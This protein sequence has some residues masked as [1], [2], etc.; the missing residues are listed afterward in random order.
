MPTPEEYSAY[1]GAH[2]SRLWASLAD[3]WRCPGCGRSRF[4]LLRWTK[5]Y[6]KK[7]HETGKYTDSY[8]GWMARLHRHHDHSVGFV[9]PDSRGRCPVTV[10]C[11]QCNSADGAA[12]RALK[13]QNDF[14]LSPEEI[15]RFVVPT[16]H[17]RHRLDLDEAS[18]IYRALCVPAYVPLCVLHFTAGFSP[19]GAYHRALQLE[20]LAESTGGP[21]FEIFSVAVRGRGVGHEH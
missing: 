12:K 4:E 19:V 8:W 3:D 10:M 11:D 5:R 2:C 21:L 20:A 1:D 16:P 9:D 18:R 13:T 15:R 6:R 14:S 7:D 17:G